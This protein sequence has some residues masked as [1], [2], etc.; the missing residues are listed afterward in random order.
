M[1]SL[2]PP[3]DSSDK[4]TPLQAATLAFNDV[5][6]AARRDLNENEHKVFLS[7][8]IVRLAKEAVHSLNREGPEDHEP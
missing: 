2:A 7:I 5:L 6:H 4:L 8:A 3:E 1:E